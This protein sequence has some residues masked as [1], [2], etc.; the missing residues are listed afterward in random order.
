M[1]SDF[2]R[3]RTVWNQQIIPVIMRSKKGRPRLRLPYADDNRRWIQNGRRNSPD[4]IN[5][6]KHWEMPM[7]WFNDL[8]MRSLDRFGSLYIIQPYAHQEKCA[9]ACMRAL[10]HECQCSCM[11]ANHGAGMTNDWLV[12]SDAFAVR[13]ERS[14]VACRLLTKKVPN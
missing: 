8:V 9:P 3:L 2:D 4:W 11:G 13:Y 12:I 6:K 14:D 10:G 1:S 7:A 5:G